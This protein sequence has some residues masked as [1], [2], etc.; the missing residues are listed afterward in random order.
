MHYLPRH[1]VIHSD[2]A[3]T[4]LH[5]D[6][7][8]S[9]KTSGPLLNECLYKGPKFQQ[10]ILDL[11]IPFRSYKVALIADVEKTFLMMPID[12]KGCDVL[13]FI[14]VHDVAKED[15]ELRVYR[16]TRVVFSVSSTPFLLNDTVK[17]HLE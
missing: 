14:W 2:K 13:R 8:A 16:F 11:L 5:V 12:E 6:Y 1:S 9:S 4:E 17:Y 3:T 10:L 7:D 15:P